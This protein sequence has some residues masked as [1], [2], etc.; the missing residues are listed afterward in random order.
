MKALF[1]VSAV[2]EL[3]AGLALLIVPSMA[4]ALLFGVP[5][6]T[7][8][9]LTITRLAGGALLAL[10]VGSGIAACGRDGR[11]GAGMIAALLVYHIAAVILFGY[12]KI[13]Y[14]TPGIPLWLVIG[15][16][17]GMT[18]WCLASLRGAT[19]PAKAGA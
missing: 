5:L 10:G 4:V 17:A 8:V 12:A 7:P 13:G 3:G 19:G 9:G 18:L 2:I 1:I 11:H 15:L 6:V 16:H 14:G